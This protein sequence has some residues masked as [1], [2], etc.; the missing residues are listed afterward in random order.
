MALGL[1]SYS[2]LLIPSDAHFT[3]EDD[4]IDYDGGKKIPFSLVIET[5]LSLKHVR[6]YIPSDLT[7]SKS[8]ECYY[9]YNDNNILVELE[10]NAGKIEEEGVEEISVR[11]AVTST[12]ETSKQAIFICRLLTEQLFM[13]VI[14]MRLKKEID[15]NNDLEIKKVIERLSL[16]KKNSTSFTPYPLIVLLLLCIVVNHFLMN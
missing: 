13:K 7:A 2:F 4:V 9:I 11:F 6:T 16:K 10:V 3:I 1:E 5:M 14:D 15:L 8:I 12:E